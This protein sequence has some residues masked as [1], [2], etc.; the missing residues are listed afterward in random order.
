MTEVPRLSSKA[1]LFGVIAIFVIDG[2]FALPM[3]EGF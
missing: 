1:V 3:T 2:C